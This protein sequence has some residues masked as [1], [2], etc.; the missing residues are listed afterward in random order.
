MFRFSLEAVLR[1]RRSTEERERLRLR[2]LQ[3]ELKEAVQELRRLVDTAAQERAG[4]RQAAEGGVWG[5]ELRLRESYA[6]SLDEMRILQQRRIEVLERECVQQI[7]KLR[8]ERRKRETLERL[9]ASQEER[10]RLAEKRAEQSRL[11]ESYLL[12]IR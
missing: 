3:Q 8:R 4:A 11:D 6:E 1:F 10:F 12:R 7:D 5:A 2:G 9:K